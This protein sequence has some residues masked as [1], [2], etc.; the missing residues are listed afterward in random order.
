MASVPVVVP[1]L[2]LGVARLAMAL[3]MVGLGE[4]GT[5]GS[6]RHGAREKQK[7]FHNARIYHAGTLNRN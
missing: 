7:L 4:G 3:G 6:E 1:M 5:G 2:G